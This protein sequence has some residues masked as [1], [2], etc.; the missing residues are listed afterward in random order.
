MQE[1]TGKEIKA[2]VLQ[3]VTKTSV[4]VRGVG[5]S[6]IRDYLSNRYQ[7][8]KIGTQLSNKLTVKF[9]IPQGTVL[10]PL[11]F[12]VYI[13]TIFQV[14]V[15]G[16]VV[17]Y[18]DDTV[19]LFTGTTWEETKNK[20]EIGMQKIN[21]FLNSN[22]LTLNTE[23]TKFITF[24]LNNSNCSNLKFL[25]L[26]KCNSI[27]NCLTCT[28]RVNFVKEIKYLGIKL[29]MFL[30][31][32][33][34]INM[35]INKLRR[36]LYFFSQLRFILDINNLKLIYISLVESVISYAIPI[37]GNAYEV[38]L[39]PL[40]VLQKKI[41]KIIYQTPNLYPTHTLF[42]LSNLSDLE[43]IYLFRVLSFIKKNKIFSETIS[44]SYSTR[45]NLLEQYIFPKANNTFYLKCLDYVGIKIFNSLPLTLRN[46][47]NHNKFKK[48][49]KKYI[50]INKLQLKLLL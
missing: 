40:K 29:D 36:L 13:N 44:H 6:L 48:E 15:P 26:H 50:Q 41:I 30:K 34:H 46:I 9:G 32:D 3:T 25:K 43:C 20:A 28:D 21:Q 1:C 12:Q 18:A 14:E 35:T 22:L 5:G 11:L 38:Y 10:G 24:S 49:V 45:A 19:L 16:K 27:E 31:W 42:Q 4:D 8:V 39:T 47:Q 37:W 17:S 7:R 33:V 23:K 2:L